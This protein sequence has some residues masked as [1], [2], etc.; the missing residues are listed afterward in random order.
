MVT[1]VLLLEVIYSA[2][3]IEL[4]SVTKTNFI[5]LSLNLIQRKNVNICCWCTYIR[6]FRITKLIAPTALIQSKFLHHMKQQKL[7]GPKNLF[8]SYNSRKRFHIILKLIQS[9]VIFTLP[10]KKSFHVDLYINYIRNIWSHM[11]WRISFT[12]INIFF[13]STEV[14]NVYIVLLGYQRYHNYYIF[15][16]GNYCTYLFTKKNH[17][18]YWLI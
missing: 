4:N 5:S 18:K 10:K 8:I 16:C 11:K 14:M 7:S 15:I 17:I 13:R 6:K 3:L 9:A 12:F 2:D 1:S